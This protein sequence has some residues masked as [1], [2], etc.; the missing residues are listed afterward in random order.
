MSVLE[1]Y[2]SPGELGLMLGFGGKWVR[3]HIADFSAFGDV[4]KIDSDYRI[5]ASAVN[6]YLEKRKIRAFAETGVAAR[7]TT[8]LKRKLR[9]SARV[10]GEDRN[11]AGA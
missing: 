3:A 4:I 9:A 5:A 8:E 7:S 6:G 1:K 10:P 11:G 2:Y